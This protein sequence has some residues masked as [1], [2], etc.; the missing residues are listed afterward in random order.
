M[1]S[2]VANH[3]PPGTGVF[4]RG[5]NLQLARE[6]VVAYLCPEDTQPLILYKGGGNLFLAKSNYV[7]VADSIERFNNLPG[8]FPSGGD[9]TYF[10]NGML[11]NVSSVRIRDVFDGTR[12]TF[13]VGEGTGN[14]GGS[15]HSRLHYWWAGEAI[16]DMHFGINGTCSM[17][18]DG[19]YCW[20]VLRP[21]AGFS[22][23]HSGGC[24]FLRVDGS[25]HFV[26]ENTDQFALEALAT[27]AGGEVLNEL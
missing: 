25:V 21:G 26:S 10:G 5:G 24:N 4:A 14:M 23:W 27:R 2:T 7:G 6:P 19:T 17:P 11:F 15:D 13:F 22:S 12:N 16:S 8:A 3:G 1:S 18:G 9:Y 20:H